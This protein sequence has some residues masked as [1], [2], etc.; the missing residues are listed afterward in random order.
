MSKKEIK[1]DLVLYHGGCPDGF[2][3]AWCFRYKYP[4]INF[5]GCCYGDSVPDVKGYNVAVVDFSFSRDQTLEMFEKANYMVILDHHE[6]AKNNLENLIIDPNKG[7]IIFDMN[8]AG[9]QLAWDYL[10]PNKKRHWLIEYVADRDLWK[11][12]LPYTEELS[13][14]LWFDGYFNDFNK[15]ENLIEKVAVLPNNLESQPIIK[16]GKLLMI[17][18]NRDIKSYAQMSVP[19][20]LKLSDK[21]VNVHIVCCPRQYRSDVGNEINNMFPTI[22]CSATY[23]YDHY[24]DQW[25]ISL[26]T[27]PNSNT[28]LADLTQNLKTGG[29]HTKAA[30]FFIKNDSLHSYFTL[31]DN[32]ICTSPKLIPLPA[33]QE[34]IDKEITGYLNAVKHNKF[35]LNDEEYPVIMTCVPIHYHKFVLDA[36]KVKFKNFQGLHI[37]YWYDF[38]RNL[39]SISVTTTYNNYNLKKIVGENPITTLGNI[40]IS[41]TETELFWCFV[42]D[43]SESGKF[44]FTKF[45]HK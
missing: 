14:A 9:A 39:W 2:T 22:D 25:W 1:F 5:K 11:K 7:E 21:L 38:G 30:G 45:F 16:K 37:V 33:L 36:I 28:N 27:G 31:D 8:R 6:S 23:W 18:K 13:F 4:L 42:E 10:Y 43:I 34:Y 12:E 32:Q 40:P 17:D 35:H 41:L 24:T 3:A 29:G 44:K 19:A 15:L 20:K 26:R